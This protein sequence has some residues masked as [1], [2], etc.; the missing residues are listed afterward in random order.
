MPQAV[1]SSVESKFPYQARGAAIAAVGLALALV[2]AS[3][4]AAPVGVD[5]GLRV[6][7]AIPLG[8]AGFSPAS[9]RSVPLS[10]LI[11]GMVPIQ[12]DAGYWIHRNILL[13]AYFQFAPGLLPSDL[14]Q[15]C[16]GARPQD[17]SIVCENV[18]YR[19]GLQGQFHFLPGQGLDPWVGLGLGFEWMTQR[20]ADADASVV[21][22]LTGFEFAHFQAGLDIHASDAFRLGPWLGL[23]LA[24]Y[25]NTNTTSRSTTQTQ[26]IDRALPSNEVRLHEWFMFGVRGAYTL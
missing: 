4:E 25:Y 18:D 2:A 26:T 20:I 14:K 13:G 7:Y 11:P 12:L 8:D 6:G 1:L 3:A 19:A 22:T 23:S 10:D 21:S 24:Q 9:G 17:P 15:L 16:D 5:L